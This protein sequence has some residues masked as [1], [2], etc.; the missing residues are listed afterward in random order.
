MPLNFPKQNEL[1]PTWLEDAWL[2]RYLDRELNDEECEWFEAYALDKSRLIDAIDTDTSLRDGLHAWHV[3]QKDAKAGADALD[4]NSVSNVVEWGGTGRP[5]SAPRKTAPWFRSLAMAASLVLAGLLGA[6]TV[7]WAQVAE[8][9]DV[10][11][12]S[13]V[14]IVFDTLRGTDS[15]PFVEHSSD[16]SAPLLIDVAVPAQAESVVAHFSDQSSL[17]LPVSADGFVSLTGPRE[18]LLQR[19]PIRIAWRLAGQSQE[20]LLDLKA[21]LARNEG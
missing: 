8:V 15:W 13:P 12:A 11:I 19:S 5:Q 16:L 10:P 7:R 9:A 3:G 18:A 6:S 17:P 1:L 4:D 2:Q 14:R 21:T 20:R